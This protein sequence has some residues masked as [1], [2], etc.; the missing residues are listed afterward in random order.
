M[1]AHRFGT[2]AG[3][4]PLTR[5]TIVATG[6][7]PAGSGNSGG[8]AGETTNGISLLASGSQAA[9]AIVVAIN[10]TAKNTIS[11]SWKAGTILQAAEDH[12][13]AL[14]YRVG[15]SGTWI[16]VGSTTTYTT[17]GKTNGEISGLQLKHYL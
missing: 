15:T 8:Y 1:A 5:T 4:I 2:T 7:L 16:D 6:D 11:V 17:L 9:G 14:Q 10:T 12:S 13:I 3:A